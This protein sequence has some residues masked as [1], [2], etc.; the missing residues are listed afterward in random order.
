MESGV[1]NRKSASQ[2]PR[3]VCR[4]WAAYYNY[5]DGIL[6]ERNL[7]SVIFITDWNV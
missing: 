5:N 2:R 6:S 7:G 4:T 3:V 1:W